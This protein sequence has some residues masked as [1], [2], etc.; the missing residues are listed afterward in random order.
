MWTQQVTHTA[1]HHAFCRHARYEQ[2][3]MKNGQNTTSPHAE[4]A[5]ECNIAQINAEITASS[6]IL[7]VKNDSTHSTKDISSVSMAG[8]MNQQETSTSSGGPSKLGAVSSFTRPAAPRA[9]PIAIEGITL[10]SPMR[11]TYLRMEMLVSK[12]ND[13]FGCGSCWFSSVIRCSA[14]IVPLIRHGLYQNRP[15]ILMIWDLFR[16][17]WPK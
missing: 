7:F 4:A 2:E 11:S 1:R 13:R 9:I 17:F 15:K 12:R 5:R 16:R 10:M 14:P 6:T 3:K 8:P